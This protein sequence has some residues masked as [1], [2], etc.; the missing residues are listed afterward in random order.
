MA[1]LCRSSCVSDQKKLQENLVDAK[2][3]DNNECIRALAKKSTANYV[4]KLTVYIT[5]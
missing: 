5:T 3:R 4:E 2:T 1:A